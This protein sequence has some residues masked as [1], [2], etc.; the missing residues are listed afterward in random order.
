MSA[1]VNLNNQRPL[2][3]SYEPELSSIPAENAAQ[4]S[5]DHSP[6]SVAPTSDR[7]SSE[8]PSEQTPLARGKDALVSRH[9][10]DKSAQL[11]RNQRAAAEDGSTSSGKTDADRFRE[12]QVAMLV[13]YAQYAQ[14]NNPLGGLSAQIAKTAEN[15]DN[16][17]EKGVGYALSYGV[18]MPLEF[19]TG[20]LAEVASVPS[21]AFQAGVHGAAALSADSAEAREHHATAAGKHALQSAKGI[22]ST[23]SVARSAATASLNVAKR[24]A[25][26]ELA[27]T[28]SLNVGEQGLDSFL[29]SKKSGTERLWDGAA[30]ALGGAASTVVTQ[31]SK[32]DGAGGAAGELVKNLVSG[33]AVKLDN[34]LRAAEN[35]ALSGSLSSGANKNHSSA[36]AAAN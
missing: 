36:V 18:G 35:A 29:Q 9:S 24:G 6:L 33:Q 5:L 34:L 23:A 28:G 7:T 11:V 8:L 1:S 15:A 17:L 13:D 27:T 30:G 4:A 20:T 22:V 26:A 32:S 3:T 16:G 2:S 14:F 21:H 10:S 12:D 31:V 25:V 19:I